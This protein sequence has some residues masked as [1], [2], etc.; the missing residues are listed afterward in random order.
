[1]KCHFRMVV[2]V[3]VIISEYDEYDDH[4]YYCYHHYPAN[5]TSKPKTTYIQ[6]QSNLKLIGSIYEY[7]RYSVASNQNFPFSISLFLKIM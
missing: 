6:P 5:G 7:L 3:K 2:V 1:M 4:N